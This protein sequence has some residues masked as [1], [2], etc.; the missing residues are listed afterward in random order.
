MVGKGKSSETVSSGKL[1]EYFGTK[2]PIIA[3][4]PDGALKMAA[5]DYKAAFITEPDNIA[6]IKNAIL[7]VYKLFREGKL[8][9]P[10]E[11]FVESFRRDLLTEQLAKQM[12]NILKV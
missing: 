11:K 3:C 8:P 6:Q 4:L 2:K 12:N 5:A 1:Y 7:E 10:D 9:I